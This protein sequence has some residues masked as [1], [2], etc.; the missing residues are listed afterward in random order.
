M[1]DDISRLQSVALVG[2]VAKEVTLITGTWV[3]LPHTL[4]RAWRGVL[5][6]AL[7]NAA[8]A[9]YFYVRHTPQD[10]VSIDLM[11]VG[12]SPDPQLELW[13]Y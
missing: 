10:D 13:I 7:L 12:Y 6:T 2:G 3:R 5:Q 11:A 9:G 1:R 4:G 8:G